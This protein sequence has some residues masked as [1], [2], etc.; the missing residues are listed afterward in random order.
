MTVPVITTARLD[1]VPVTLEDAAFV[2]AEFP[3]WE[4]VEF[5]N[6]RVPWPYP[7]DGALVFLRDV[8]L[9]QIARG[10]ARAWT[11]RLRDSG[12]P[13]GQINLRIGTDEHR[14][15][16]IARAFQRCGYVTEAVAAVTDHYFEILGQPELRVSKAVQNTAS[17][18][19]SLRQGMRLVATDERDYV[20]GRH[21]TEIWALT[22][23][24]WRAARYRH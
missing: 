18:A 15:F 4:I 19:V 9:P 23:E 24:E 14:G 17:R 16:W 13:I 6:A 21:P 2:Q 5:M 20:S 11:I 3:H 12:T 7:A 10:E 1:L 22:R 8:L